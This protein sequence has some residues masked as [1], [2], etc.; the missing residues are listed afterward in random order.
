MGWLGGGQSEG[1]GRSGVQAGQ[2]WGRIGQCSEAW[3]A[4]GINRGCGITAYW[5]GI[6]WSTNEG[7]KVA[8]PPNT[9]T[10]TTLI[11]PGFPI[12]YFLSLNSSAE[13][14][15]RWWGWKLSLGLVVINNIRGLFDI[16]LRGTFSPQLQEC[17]LHLWDLLELWNDNFYAL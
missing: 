14:E 8:A 10:T 13:A 2:A 15:I 12:Y 7:P 11:L 5:V 6:N 1:F 9:H 4:V 16:P 3:A 17:L